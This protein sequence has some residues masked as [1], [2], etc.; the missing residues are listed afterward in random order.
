VRTNGTSASW[1]AVHNVSSIPQ[2]A[3]CAA[4]TEPALFAQGGVTYLASNCVVFSGGVRQENLERLVLLRQESNGYSYVGALTDY[5]DAVYLGGTRFEQADLAVAQNG[6][7][8]LIGTPIQNSQPNHLGCVVLEITD[9][10]AAQVRRDGAGDP[11]KLAAITGQDSTIGPGLCTYD[12]S[13]TTGVLMVLHAQSQDPP[14]TVFSL[15]ATGVHPNGVDSD[16][17]GVAD[18]VD[19][20]DDNDMLVDAAEVACGS[21]PVVAASLPERVDGP[22]AGADDDGDTQVD[23]ALPAGASDFD[24]DGDGYKGSAEDHVSSYLPQPMSPLAQPSPDQKTCQE[25]DG[26]FPNPGAHVRPSKRW[27]ADIASSA[28]SLNKV[29]VQDL[30]SFT[31]PVRYLNQDVGTDPADVRFDLSPA[32]PLGINIADMAALTNGATAFPPM[33]GGARSF[34][35]PACPWAP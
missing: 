16:G 14:Q 29:N 24:C 26:T 10:G 35:G 3:D 21:D 13:S 22:F 7:V 12:A 9:I 27:P 30:S 15:R 25:Y 2:L 8:L 33:L 17:D 11:V 18:S 1:G 32:A 23:E 4:L 19:A 31:T 6:A 34:G 5:S 28:F 20:N